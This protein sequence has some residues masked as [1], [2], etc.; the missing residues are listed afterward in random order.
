MRPERPG[1]RWAPLVALC[2]V[3]A[4]VEAG[5]V[6]AT[7]PVGA[8][9]LG[10][11]A[12]PV[13]PFGVFQDLRW[14]AVYPSSW[15]LVALSLTAVVVLRGALTGAT[16]AAAWPASQPRP[17]LGRLL[18]RGMLSTAV[19]GVLLA[20]SAAILYGLAVVPVS[21]LFLA[22]VPA[23]LFVA[24]LVNPVAVDRGWWRRPVPLRAVAWVM[25]DFAAISVAAAVVGADP[26]V[27]AVPVALAAGVVDA[28]AWAG[29]VR[30]VV[31]QPQRRLVLPMVPVGVVVLVAAVIGGTL[32]GFDR[33]AR[34]A[35]GA[36]PPSR[37]PAAPARPAAGPRR[38][39]L[40]LVSGYGSHWGGAPE[41][42]V[43]GAFVEEPFSYRGLT[44]G[45]RPLPYGARQTVAGVAVL[46][47]R[48]HRQIDVLAARTGGPIDVVAESEGTVVLEYLLHHLSGRLP[49]R[50][51]VL[52]SPLPDPARVSYPLDGSTGA[53]FATRD[54]LGAIVGAFQG[55]APIDLSPRSAFIRSLDDSSGRDLQVCPVAGVRQYALL[56]LA[57]AVA[58][59]VPAPGPDIPG[60]VV[61]AFH[62]GQLTDP[63]VDRAVAA[64]LHTGR[65]PPAPVLSA[66]EQVVRAAAAAWWVPAPAPADCS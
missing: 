7:G 38:T 3:P 18:A 64:I 4:V 41:H 8:L 42:P 52:A 66:A 57:D 45:G 20:P 11:Q 31:R 25:A 37:A 36:S 49:L 5:V 13:P 14:V 60:T 53:G 1:P 2:T 17:P 16:V 55:A 39:G 47:A 50:S 63:A 48:L 34:A 30:A 26:V 23:A 9:A 54:A 58:D 32:L 21:W 12:N 28:V 51:V 29:L 61:A 6:S 19:A 40:L 59:P 24:L 35:A 46:A 10:P 22:A 15:T 65:L 62:G 43:P 27:A 33:A 56:P 44:A